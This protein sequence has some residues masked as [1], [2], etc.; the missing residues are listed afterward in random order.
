MEPDKTE[1]LE[2][3]ERFIE[4]PDFYAFVIMFV[5]PMGIVLGTRL[6]KTKRLPQNRQYGYR[7][8][9]YGII[10]S[11][12][13]LAVGLYIAVNIHRMTEDEW[14]SIPALGGAAY[15]LYVAFAYDVLAFRVSR[16]GK[17]F[18]KLHPELVGEVRKPHLV[19]TVKSR[20][21][22]T[23]VQDCDKTICRDPECKFL[24]KPDSDFCEQCGAQ[25]KE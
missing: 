21:G 19:R 11:L 9:K 1:Q 3:K 8:I 24:N 12:I 14:R 5:P 17:Q 7:C 16:E 15:F 6:L 20:K 25:L 10:G 23:D 18:I 22:K 13:L 2:K 4:S